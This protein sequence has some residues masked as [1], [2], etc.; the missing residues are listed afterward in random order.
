MTIKRIVSVVMRVL[1]LPVLLIYRLEA[2]CVGEMKAFG[3]VTQWVSLVPGLTGEWFRRAFLQWHT[4]LRLEDCCISFG[5]TFSDPRVVIGNGVYMGRSCDIGYAEI[6]EN[7]MIGSSVHILS[8]LKQH[9]FDDLDTPI[10]DQPREF[11]KVTIGE[12]TWIGNGAII[13]TDVGRK[14][15]IGAGAVVVKPLPDYAIAVGNPAR[16]VRYRAGRGE[17]TKRY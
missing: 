7:C 1:S 3:M 5:T 15:I 2:L 16:I 13:A 9:S 12:D 8:G 6:G 14:C 10:K 11:S 17:E 4:G